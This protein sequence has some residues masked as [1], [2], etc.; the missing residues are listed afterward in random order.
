MVSA[1]RRR[2]RPD[3]RAADAL[4]RAG[5]SLGAAVSVEGAVPSE[6]AV[7]EELTGLSLGLRA[8]EVWE[9]AM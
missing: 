4:V 2:E 6:G 3:V 1:G 7:V 5:A 8:R 9:L